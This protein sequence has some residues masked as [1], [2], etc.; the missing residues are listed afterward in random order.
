[1]GQT[2]QAVET[3]G[4]GGGGKQMQTVKNEAQDVKK[5][6]RKVSLCDVLML[7]VV[8]LVAVC[9]ASSVVCVAL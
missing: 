6:Q 1:M 9:C 4:K 3:A 2:A 8:S 7:S 5:K